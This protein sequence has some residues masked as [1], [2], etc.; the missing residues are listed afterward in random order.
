MKKRTAHVPVADGI[1]LDFRPRSYGADRDP[2]A[3]IVQNIK[4]QNRRR[5]ARAFVAGDMPKDFGP[6]VD[7]LLEDTL[8][9]DA[10]VSLGQIH[11]SFM[12][13][14]YLPDYQR[15]EVEIARVVLASVTQDVYSAAS[16]VSVESSVYQEL[17]R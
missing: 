11:P 6:I 7:E 16:F 12:G 1:D 8:D 3:T 4:G 5:M 13:G 2:I 15:S 9:N 10:R 17:E 14:E